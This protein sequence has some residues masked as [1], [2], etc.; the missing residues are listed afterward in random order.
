MFKLGLGGVL[1]GSVHNIGAGAEQWK[2]RE[3]PGLGV[4]LVTLC[5]GYKVN[6]CRLVQPL[7]RYD[8]TPTGSKG[9]KSE[10]VRAHRT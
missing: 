1:R 3:V 9:W 4:V 2:V 6:R 7:E 5:T 10:F 8:N